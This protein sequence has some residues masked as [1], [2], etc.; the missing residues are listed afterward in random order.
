MFFYD[1]KYTEDPKIRHHRVLAE[2][3]FLPLAQATLRPSPV[4]GNGYG[5][6]QSYWS[7]KKPAKEWFYV[8]LEPT[9]NPLLCLCL[10]LSL[11]FSCVN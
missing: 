6:M 4:S 3:L 8:T 11:Y 7:G 9:P 5:R 1:L 10:R 2:F